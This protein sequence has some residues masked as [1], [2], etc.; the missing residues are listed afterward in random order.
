MAL[1]SV[2]TAR[3]SQHDLNRPCMIVKALQFPPRCRYL[4]MLSL[5]SCIL[6]LRWGLLLW[7]WTFIEASIVQELNDLR[8][9]YGLL[10]LRYHLYYP[11]LDHGL[12]RLLLLMLLVLLSVVYLIRG[13]HLVSMGLPMRSRP[14]HLFLGNVMI[15]NNLRGIQ[16]VLDSWE[17][18]P[19]C[20]T[21]SSVVV[22]VVVVAGA[23]SRRSRGHMLA[24]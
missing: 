18:F 19:I 8:R 24:K 5:R 22:H 23:V 12:L 20:P 7:G 3:L 15:I 17:E 10:D 21:P 1:C 6:M 4:L 2:V 16:L 11:F 14:T 9:E 13:L